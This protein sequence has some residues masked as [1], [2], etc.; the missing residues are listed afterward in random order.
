MK[1]TTIRAAAAVLALLAATAAVSPALARKQEVIY[2]NL[3]SAGGVE[4][5]YVVNSFQNAGT[6]EDYGRYTAVRTMVGPQV[7]EPADGKVTCVTGGAALTY[8]GTLDSR[9]LPWVF[10]V[11]YTLDGVP[12]TADELAGQSGNVQ[13]NFVI[14][15]SRDFVNTVFFRHYSLQVTFL[16]DMARCGGLPDAPGAT[17]SFNGNRY[18]M[19]FTVLPNREDDLTVTFHDVSDFQM[20]GIAVNGMYL[21]LSLGMAGGDL[22]YLGGNLEELQRTVAT[23]NANARTAR[24]GISE[25]YNA[26]VKL[27]ESAD[28][29][30][31]QMPDVV[32]SVDGVNGGTLALGAS[33]DNVV[34][35]H[36]FLIE[37]G[38]EIFADTL[39][40]AQKQ[41]AAI[42]AAAEL[43]ENPFD[44]LNFVSKLFEIEQQLTA[45]G[46][47]DESIAVIPAL[48]A[49]LRSI[50][51][52]NAALQ[53]Y[54]E[55]VEGA[56]GSTS[57][58]QNDAT[59]LQ[60][61][62]KPFSDSAA[63]TF[64]SVGAIRT[65]MGD[66]NDRATAIAAETEMIYRAVEDVLNSLKGTLG[67]VF[68][69]DFTPVSFTSGRNQN[70]QMVQFAFKTPAVTTAVSG[71]AASAPVKT[72]FLQRLAN[73][74]K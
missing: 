59:D 70:V 72:T 60:L 31:A 48:T 12:V 37:K 33:M 1:K 2:A 63:L 34:K 23:M 15:Q 3:D 38:R 7:S 49:Q 44:A 6:V 57:A 36:K 40:S 19:T 39:S 8:E 62:F 42:L 35:E 66:V 4:T 41:A 25:L 74:F 53:K 56:A 73:L 24:D 10:A 17:L 47:P 51:D 61:L 22:G 69:G 54:I 32:R 55:S 68:G 46:A 9:D 27:Q 64:T 26:L 45:A 16:F 11:S 29:L 20:P 13:I 52:Y 58:L 28:G 71:K 21:E 67:D 30:N 43:P 18:Q 50:R 5:I 14:K 65:R